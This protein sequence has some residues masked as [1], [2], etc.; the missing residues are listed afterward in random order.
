LRFAHLFSEHVGLSFGRYLLWRRVTRAVLLASGG[1]SLSHAAHAAG[2]AD[3]AHFTRTFV[4]MFG[5]APSERMRD[6]LVFQ[7]RSP[8]EGIAPTDP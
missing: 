8:F 4:K 1:E 2:F 5:I 6:G 7:I 3:A